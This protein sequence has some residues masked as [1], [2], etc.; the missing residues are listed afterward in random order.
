MNEF[1]SLGVSFALFKYRRR[2][3]LGL[4]DVRW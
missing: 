3:F 4:S 1:V 2:R